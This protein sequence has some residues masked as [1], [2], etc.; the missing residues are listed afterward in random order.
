ML[1]SIIIPTFNSEKYIERCLDA[2][3][4]QTY[5]NLEV[6]IVDAGSTDKTFEF[7]QKYKSTL[8]I[9]EFTLA[10]STQSEARN[11]GLQHATG[12]YIAFCDSDDFYLPE[13]I[14]KQINAF[15]PNTDV[16]YFDVLHFYTKQPNRYFINKHP[17]TDDIF[18]DCIANQVINL[19][20][21]MVSKKFLDTK[22]IKFPECEMGRYGEDG[23]FIFQLAFHGAKFYKLSEHLSVVEVREDSHTQWEA[24]WKMKLYAIKYRENVLNQ[25]N[26]KY[27]VLLKKAIHRLKFKLCLAYLVI[28]EKIEAEKEL[29]Q[30]SGM[31]VVVISGLLK[32][33]P[34]SLIGQIIKFVWLKR[35]ASKE[36]VLQ[37]D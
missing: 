13:K 11:L 2:I 25:V 16:V 12:D 15:T 22:Q 26:H 27:E 7:I 3:A 1:V 21:V 20:S 32:V 6:L 23:N 35:K 10:K 4:A 24:Q 30:L 18:A 33:V 19:N 36:Q 34:I 31:Q 8:N 37:M 17:T 14:E 28:G 29:K 5:K 9:R